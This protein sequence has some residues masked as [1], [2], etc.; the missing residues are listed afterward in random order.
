MINGFPREKKDLLDEAKRI[1]VTAAI[2]TNK[3]VT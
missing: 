2:I 3:H 1:I